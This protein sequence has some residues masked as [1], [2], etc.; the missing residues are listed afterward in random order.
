[1]QIK[2]RFQRDIWQDDGYS[3]FM[4]INGNDTL[5]N[6]GYDGIEWRKDMISFVNENNTRHLIVNLHYLFDWQGDLADIRICV[7]LRKCL[8]IKHPNLSVI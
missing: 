3:S 8:N 5:R 6:R 2:I 4:K 7:C 1:M